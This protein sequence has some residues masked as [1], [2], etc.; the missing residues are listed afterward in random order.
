MP[1]IL[2]TPVRASKAYGRSYNR[3]MTKSKSLPSEGELK[4]LCVLWRQGPSTVHEV[5]EALGERTT[6]TTVLKLLQIMHRKGFVRRDETNRAHI[7]RSKFS[8][9]HT[10]RKLVK[11]LLE[12]AFESSVA[13]LV[14]QALAVTGAKADEL[15]EVGDV[16]RKYGQP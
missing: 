14:K 4:I 13:S 6:Y 2:G 5:R 12:L 9:E 16:L 10:Q 7:Y 15:E 3:P 11:H 1:R 8:A